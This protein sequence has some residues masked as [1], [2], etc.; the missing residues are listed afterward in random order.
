[1]G[2]TYSRKSFDV[3]EVAG[4]FSR[5]GQVFDIF[6]LYVNE[7]LYLAVV[8][9]NLYYETIHFSFACCVCKRERNGAGYG[10]RGSCRWYAYKDVG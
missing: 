4:A 10:A 8:L 1:M 3:I 9:N 5:Y 6:L 7:F 2:K